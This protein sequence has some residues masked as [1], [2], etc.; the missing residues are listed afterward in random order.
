MGNEWLGITLYHHLGIIGSLL[1]LSGMLYSIKKRWDRP[2]G[3]TPFWLR[4][5]ELVSVVGAV[6]VIIH[7]EGSLLGLAGASIL[8][9]LVVSVSGFLG[10]Y[11]Y[12]RIPR[13]SMGKEKE[14][15]ELKSELEKNTAEMNENLESHPDDISVAKLRYK[16]NRT[17]RQIR[18]LENARRLLAG[19]RTWHIPMTALFLLVVVIHI[20][21]MLYYGSY[22]G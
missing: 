15:A 14:L 4:Y 1:M 16:I 2:A 18:Q 9:M 22:L 20:L 12:T 6:L 5:H 7:T 10:H 19:W 21:S 11:I 13:N 3:S 8:M 17:E